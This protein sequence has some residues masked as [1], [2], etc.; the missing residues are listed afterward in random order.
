MS[1]E[2]TQLL[3]DWRSGAPDAQAKLCPL[4]YQELRRL[5]HRYMRQERGG[6]TLQ[7]TALVHEAWLRLANTPE[8]NWRNRGQFFALSAQLMR[9]ILV[10]YARRRR[11][12]KRGG[13]MPHVSWDEALEI[14]RQ[15]SDELLALDD[16][17]SA[18]AD[19]DPR[20]GQVVELRFYGGLSV[21]ET[22]AALDVSPDT[23]MRDWKLA[24]AWLRREMTRQ[25]HDAA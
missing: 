24:K 16:A 25:N 22:A 4:V 10:D 14:A 13:E 15:R 2:I 1:H 20:K 18:L 3:M 9:R 21:E 17:L 7:T 11:A 19:L 5:A 12:T 23:V 6:H 8:I